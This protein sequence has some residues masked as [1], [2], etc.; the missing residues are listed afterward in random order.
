MHLIHRK[1]IDGIGGFWWVF[2][3]SNKCNQIE[4]GKEETLWSLLFKRKENDIK[5]TAMANGYNG[6]GW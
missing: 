3:Q 6:T 2:F 1:L 4:P 5:C